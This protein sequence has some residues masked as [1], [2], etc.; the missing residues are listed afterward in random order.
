MPQYVV[1]RLSVCHHIGWSNS[2][3]ISRLISLRF[4]ADLNMGDMVQRE[5]PQD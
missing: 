1:T 3:I 2:I 4:R 5:Q